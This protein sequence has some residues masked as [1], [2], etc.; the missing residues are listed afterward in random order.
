M[1][2]EKLVSIVLPTYNRVNLLKKA[3]SSLVNQTYKNIEILVGDNHSEDGTEEYMREEAAKDPRI[4][5]FRWDENIGAYN[6]TANLLKHMS[7]EYFVFFNDDDWLDLNYVEECINFIN[8]NDGYAFVAPSVILYKE[9][10]TIEKECFAPDLT[11]NNAQKRISV[12]L[13]NY[14]RSDIVSGFF[15]K[16]VMDKM[17]ECD[18]YLFKRRIVEDVIFMMRA[19]A[20]GKGKVLTNVH[21]RKLNNGATR[22]LDNITEDFCDTDGITKRNFLNVCIQTLVDTIKEDKIFLLSISNPE[23]YTKKLVPYLKS[24]WGMN[25]LLKLRR[26][27]RFIKIYRRVYAC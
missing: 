1:S 26:F 14:W 27:F 18:G 4:K 7:G 20:V 8:K 17:L 15:S 19:L 24:K 12:L 21:Y 3:L 9:D 6:N 25:K 16:K 5:Y 10:Y 22:V 23:Y 11:S 13:E 2:E